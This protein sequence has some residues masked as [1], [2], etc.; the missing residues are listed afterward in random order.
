[1]SVETACV[2]KTRRNET[3]DLW[4]M[5]LGHV[6]YSKLDVMMKRSMLKGLPQLEVRKGTVYAGCQ[7]GKTPIAI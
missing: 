3:T 2:D 1:M 6:S 4:H 7:Y 5:R